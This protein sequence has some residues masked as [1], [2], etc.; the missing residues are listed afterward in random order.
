MKVR[1]NIVVSSIGDCCDV[2]VTV[3]KKPMFHDPL[4]DAVVSEGGRVVL[5]CHYSGEPAPQVQ[6]FRGDNPI[7]PSSVFKVH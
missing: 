1:A 6:W 3:V 5:E 2:A 7:L 4:Q